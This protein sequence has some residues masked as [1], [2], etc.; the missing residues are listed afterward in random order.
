MD[1]S[2]KFS[3][4]EASSTEESE[5]TPPKGAT[6]PSPS[7]GLRSLGGEGVLAPNSRKTKAIFFPKTEVSPRQT[8]LNQRK[9]GGVRGCP[10]CELET[11]STSIKRLTPPPPVPS[12][13]SQ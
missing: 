2:L 12:G 11:R 13:V 1:T 4:P 7:R 5:G 10:K 8:S 3:L 6:P 9:E